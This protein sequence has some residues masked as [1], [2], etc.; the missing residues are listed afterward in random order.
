MNIRIRE[1]VLSDANEFI[2]VMQQSEHLHHPWT[3]APKTLE[4][5]EQYI[6][7][8]SQLNQKGFLVEI[9]ESK[10]AGVFNISEIVFGCF[11]SGY[12]GYYATVDHAGKGVMSSALKLVLKNAFEKIKLHR[13][14]ANIQPENERSCRL[15]KTNG[16]R[17]EGFS[18]RYLKID[19][20][21]C[22]HERWAMTYEDWAK[23]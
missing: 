6:E 15:I 1:P 21:W 8:I 4:A 13:I 9:A 11:Q 2:K 23:L 17:K 7:R 10:I 5:F 12:L 3:N 14:E 22:D 16:F 20:K 18:P 19:G